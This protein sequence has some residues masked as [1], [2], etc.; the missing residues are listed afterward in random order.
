VT[1]TLVAGLTQGGEPETATRQRPN[2]QQTNQGNPAR[3]I[4]RH[5]ASRPSEG[6]LAQSEGQR[7]T[8]GNAGNNQGQES[9]IL[10]CHGNAY[11]QGTNKGHGNV[12]QPLARRTA[13][14]GTCGNFGIVTS[15]T[16]NVH[17]LKEVWPIHIN[18]P[19]EDAAV[20]I[21]EWPTR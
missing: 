15:L 1:D 13:P 18:W 5:G 3:R 9:G 7:D 12:H 17:K 21:A 8:P 6:V 19:I 10:E 14:G 4:S 16:Y 11:V 2:T 20:V